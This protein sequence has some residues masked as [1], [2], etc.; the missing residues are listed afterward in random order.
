MKRWN[1]YMVLCNKVE[2][3]VTPGKRFIVSPST[4]INSRSITRDIN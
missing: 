2:S 1:D 4:C 3:I